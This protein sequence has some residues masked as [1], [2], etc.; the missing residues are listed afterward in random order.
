MATFDCSFCGAPL[1]DGTDILCATC[2][3]EETAGPDLLGALSSAIDRARAD[4]R[5]AK[6]SESES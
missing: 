2:S 5:A 1:P 6:P 4:R 3:Y